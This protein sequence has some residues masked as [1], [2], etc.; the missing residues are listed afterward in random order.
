MVSEI[1]G[2]DPLDERIISTTADAVKRHLAPGARLIPNRLKLCALPVT[3]PEHVLNKHVFT[4]QLAKVWQGFYGLDF[5]SFADA[6]SKQSY[7]TLVNTCDAGKWPCLS[8]P[9]LI[10]D[11]RLNKQLSDMI[12]TRG[13]FEISQSGM[14]SGMLLYFELELSKNRTFSIHPRNTDHNN[15]WAS[16]L[17]I[18]GKPIKVESGWQLK[19]T[20]RYDEISKSQFEV[21][22]PGIKT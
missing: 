21:S 9:V 2:N 13:M 5:S 20:Y 16:K 12:E 6:G 18:P 15:S 11:F 17:W 22:T 4:K 10:A 7:S 8:K 14:L 19:Y 1:I 3:V